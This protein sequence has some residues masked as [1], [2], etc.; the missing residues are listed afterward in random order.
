MLDTKPRSLE[1]RAM[2]TIAVLLAALC[3]A[4][5]S[6]GGNEITGPT[7]SA[8]PITGRLIEFFSRGTVAAATIE[9]RTTAGSPVTSTVSDANGQYSAT[10]PRG[11]EYLVYIG[12]IPGGSA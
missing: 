8:V 11:G 4:A 10:L 6:D 7:T 12:G 9:F 3:A 2:K 1:T 5:C